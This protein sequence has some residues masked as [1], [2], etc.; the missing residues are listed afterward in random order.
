VFEYLVL[1]LL[2]LYFL[3][4]ILILATSFINN[5]KLL[6]YINIYKIDIKFVILAKSYIQYIEQNADIERVKT[7]SYLRQQTTI[8]R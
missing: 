8:F 1:L 2:L 3:Y 6:L 7:F 4:Q 5:T